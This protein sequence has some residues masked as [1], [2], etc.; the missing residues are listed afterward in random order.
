MMKQLA[1]SNIPTRWGDFE[2]I[3]FGEDLED[4]TPHLAVL[5]VGQASLSDV[6]VRIHSECM[7]GDLFGSA[8]CDCGD[9]L[10]RSM[11]RIAKEGGVLIYL[12]QE[13]RGIGLS[14]KLQAYALQDEG[15]NTIEANLRL[16][17]QADERSYGMGVKILQA[18]GV[19]SIRLLT[20]NPDK[21][22]AI[23]ESSIQLIE[24]IPLVIPPTRDNDAYL[25]TKKKEMG[26]LF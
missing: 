13:G 6:L 12:R 1:S 5:S 21:I 24:R 19:T 15:L 14:R 17:H 23:E 2:M 11:E 20:N 8:R 18:L 3:A 16:G 4:P 25:E 7:T 9:Q 10:D 26:H 22:K